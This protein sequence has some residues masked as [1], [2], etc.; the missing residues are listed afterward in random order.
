LAP[1]FDKAFFHR[2]FLLAC[3]TAQFTGTPGD[4]CNR[5]R[6]L[7]DTFLF[8]R[9]ATRQAVRIARQRDAPVA[10]PLVAARPDGFGDEPNARA[11]MC[12]AATH[13]RCRTSLICAYPC[14]FANLD[15]LVPLISSAALTWA[16]CQ[17]IEISRFVSMGLI[18]H[19]NQVFTIKKNM[20]T[21]IYFA[22]DTMWVVKRPR[23]V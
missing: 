3:G 21:N 7:F 4:G 23:G 13:G 19:T 17:S 15:R 10:R 8:H 18:V 2:T 20:K 16:G 14:C 11:T 22:F 9:P 5:H 1:G 6:A 12:S